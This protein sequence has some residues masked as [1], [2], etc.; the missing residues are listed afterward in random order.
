MSF[1]LTSIRA[2]CDELLPA[3][4][5]WLQEGQAQNPRL[6]NINLMS[7]FVT[8]S[9]VMGVSY[10]LFTRR[11]LDTGDYKRLFAPT[12]QRLLRLD[13]DNAKQV[14]A[15]RRRLFARGDAAR[16]AKPRPKLLARK[17]A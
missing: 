15:E 2:R 14:R 4:K 12:M 9:I 6:E 1:P 8:D 11:E 5:H 7:D 3:V 16:S 13:G 10:K 17:A